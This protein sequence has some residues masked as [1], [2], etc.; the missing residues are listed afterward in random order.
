[1]PSKTVTKRCSLTQ[2]PK[3]QSSRGCSLPHM[4]AMKSS[5]QAL[6]LTAKRREFTFQRI[7]TVLIEAPLDFGGG[8]SAFFR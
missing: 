6:E 7:K 1:M 3:L 5:N 8:S 4:H 2:M